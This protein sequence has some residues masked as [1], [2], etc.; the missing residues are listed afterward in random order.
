MVM[1]MVLQIIRMTMIYKVDDY[2]KDGI[3]GVELDDV[4]D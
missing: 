3:S 1:T 4:K 2:Y